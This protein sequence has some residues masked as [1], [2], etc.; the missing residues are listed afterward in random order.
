MPKRINARVVKLTSPEGLACQDID[1]LAGVP[2]RP[3]GRSIIPFFFE[4]SLVIVTPI[5]AS[6][7]T[8]INAT[9]MA[10]VD[11]FDLRAIDVF[12]RGDARFWCSTRIRARGGEGR[13]QGESFRRRCSRRRANSNAKQL[14]ECASFHENLPRDERASSWK[15]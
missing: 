8:P 11:L 2:A 12:R 7:D 9:P 13:E 10:V 6:T 15:R 1:D 14:Q 5:N 3:G 4:T